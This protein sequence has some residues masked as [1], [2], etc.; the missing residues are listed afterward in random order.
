VVLLAARQGHGLARALS[1]QVADDVAAGRLKVVLQAH[2]PP[3]IP[4]HLVHAEGRRT[5]AKVR[6]FLDFSVARL[7]ADAALAAPGLPATG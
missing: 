3:P 5:T 4:I 6:A 1:Y 2:E 7:R